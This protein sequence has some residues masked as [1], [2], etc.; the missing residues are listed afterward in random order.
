MPRREGAT[1]TN[2]TAVSSFL[3]VVRMVQGFA[4]ELMT[5]FIDFKFSCK[6]DMQS[7]C[8]SHRRN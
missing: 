1:S 6:K 5:V 3:H 2:V 4:W 8:V 7:S